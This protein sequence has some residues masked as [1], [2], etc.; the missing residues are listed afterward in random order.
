[1]IAVFIINRLRN[2]LGKKTGN[3][4]DI[5]KKYSVDRTSSFKESIPDE[6]SEKSPNNLTKKDLDKKFH[7]NPKINE[8]LK[9]ISQHNN[10]FSIESFIEGAKKAFEYIIKSYSQDKID[11][12][13]KLVSKEMLD[14]FSTEIKNRKKNRQSLNIT[15]IGIEKPEITKAEI[16][17][18]NLIKI[19]LKFITEQIQVTKNSKGQIVEGDSNQILSITEFWTFSKKITN[20]DP[21]WTLEEIQEN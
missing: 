15:L 2:T 5:V 1:M 10:D 9:K 12:L 3:E 14:I 19:T 17:S 11:S 13:K 18:K 21:N 6:V 8:A 20:K 7:S 4:S 16:S